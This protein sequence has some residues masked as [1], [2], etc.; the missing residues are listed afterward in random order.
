MQRA[1]RLRMRESGRVYLRFAFLDWRKDA[2]Y[3]FDDAFTVVVARSHQS[4]CRTK[5]C[6]D[7]H[8]DVYRY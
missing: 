1:H 4:S 5:K 7:V 2:E 8:C 6:P 3:V